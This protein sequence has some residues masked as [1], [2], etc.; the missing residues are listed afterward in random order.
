[1]CSCLLMVRVP[2]EK[3]RLIVTD[4]QTTLHD[5]HVMCH[6]SFLSVCCIIDGFFLI[7]FFPPNICLPSGLTRK[8]NHTVLHSNPLF[9]FCNE[10]SKYKKTAAV[11]IFDSWEFVNCSALVPRAH[12][13]WTYL[14]VLLRGKSCSGTARCLER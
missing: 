12:L 8:K 13:C 3:P 7:L 4:G 14:P 10:S 11:T 1:M 9:A 5:C 2:T 6:V